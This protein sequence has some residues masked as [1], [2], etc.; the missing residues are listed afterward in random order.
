MNAP[1]TQPDERLAQAAN[2]L[3]ERPR[4]QRARLLDAMIELA[5]RGGS[6]AV[7]VA[8]VSSAAGVS[9]A[10]FYAE[11]ENKEECLLAA[12]AEAAR[13]LLMV[14]TPSGGEEDW[15]S[16]AHATIGE[17]AAAIQQDPEA[18]RLLFID[19]LSGGLRGRKTRAAALGAFAGR[20]QEFIDSYPAQQ[21]VLDLP[22]AALVGATRSIIAR[23]LRTRGESEL[24]ALAEHGL[25]WVLSYR[26]APGSER[27]STTERAL[28]PASFEVTPAPSAASSRRR[29]PRGRH[30]LPAGVIARSHRTRIL[31][32][33]AEVMT[34]KGYAEATVADIVA[35]A[36]VSRDVFYEHFTDKQHAF[37][38]AQ[39]HPTQHILE[40]C[41]CAYFAEQQWPERVW[42]MLRALLEMIARN[43]AMSHLR[44]VECYAAGPE[45]IRRAEEITR[46]FTIFLEEGYSQREQARELPRLTLQAITGAAF[47]LIQ[48]QVARG[49]GSSLPRL[50]PM[51]CYVHVAPFMG[52]EAAVEF[53]SARIEQA[54]SEG[55]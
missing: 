22:P 6:Q 49:R 20:V 17:L 37:L 14:R 50:L 7:T 33:T 21:G 1:T 54:S 16:A 24:P 30:G 12:Y 46:S 48:R 15:R 43:P 36:G 31:Y 29:L 32:G 35:S 39:N 11:F 3:P 52:A 34:D 38:E 51:L 28:L 26:R 23:A 18:G 42:A 25:Q 55:A 44:L 4:T 45:A 8:Q 13:R 40:S 53:L 5:G 27:F 19:T 9:S 47:E 2:S 41:A 10:T